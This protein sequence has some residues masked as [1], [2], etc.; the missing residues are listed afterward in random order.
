MAIAAPVILAEMD[1]WVALGGKNSGIVGNELH[2]YG[3]HRS[4]SEV[5]ATDYS[6]RRDPNGADGPFISWDYACAGDF[7]HG[8]NERLRT[9]HREVLA[10]LM[11]NDPA[12]SMICEMITMPWADRPVYYWARWEGYANLRQYTGSGHDLWSHISWYRS[13]A[14]QRPH[15]WT[16]GVNMTEMFPRYGEN[17]DG[18]GYVQF[19]LENLGY[20]VGIVDNDYRDKTALALSK[21]VLAYNGQNV[22]GKRVTPAIKIYLDVSM[23]RKFGK[24][25]PEGPRGPQG[26]QGIQGVEG[27]QGEKGD[28]GELVLPA[29]FNFTGTVTPG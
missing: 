14:N 24:P 4:A 6:R 8:G 3:F 15:L 17:H 11:A 13:R 25:G 22:D 23:N 12:L 26:I 18:V 29:T 28:P 27:K 21:F 7:Y 19:Q 1:D 10:R 9:M 5:P 20:D 16:T 2:N